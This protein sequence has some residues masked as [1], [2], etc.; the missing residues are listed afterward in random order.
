MHLVVLHPWREGP[1]GPI[2]LLLD[3]DEPSLH[4]G[5]VEAPDE[6]SPGDAV[7]D[8]EVLGAFTLHRSPDDR[9]PEVAQAVAELLADRMPAWL[10]DRLLELLNNIHG[11]GTSRNPRGSA[12]KM[13]AD[14]PL[15][16]LGIWGPAIEKIGREVRRGRFETWEGV[17]AR[18]EPVVHVS[19]EEA[20]PQVLRDDVLGA[21][22]PQMLLP[23]PL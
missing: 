15:A 8:A 22:K 2:T 4:L 12:A 17:L 19:I 6:A 18:L 3:P 1:K 20:I 5:L 21:R 11:F 10:E 16:P 23:E 7:E 14:H 13:G 9:V